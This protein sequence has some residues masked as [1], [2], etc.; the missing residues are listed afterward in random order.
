MS[1]LSKSEN[2]KRVVVRD[3]VGC[4]STPAG[5]RRVSRWSMDD[6]TSFAR[7]ATVVSAGHTVGRD[8]TIL[9]DPT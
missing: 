2:D 6:S 5:L 7:P 8:E 4:Q 1:H 3:V 9:S